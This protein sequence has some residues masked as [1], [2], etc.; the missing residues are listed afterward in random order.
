M[1]YVVELAVETAD[2]LTIEA[3]EAVAE[4]AGAA[5]GLAGSHRLDVM[6]SVEAG[7]LAEA[8]DRAIDMTLD[9]LAGKVLAAEAM[10]EAEAD[11]R[12][13]EPAFPDL[14]GVTEAASLLGIS[15]QRVHVLRERPEFPAPVAMLAAGPIWRKGDLS[16]FSDGW[17]RKA[18][19]PR[20]ATLSPAAAP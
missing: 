17:K 14:I 12:L 19:R 7:R 5:A 15:R 10:T 13:A 6:L 20:K 4:V 18:G 1:L 11:R 8:T 9:V 16:T 2:P 3:L